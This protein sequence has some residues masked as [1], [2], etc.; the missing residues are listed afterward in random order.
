MTHVEVSL[1]EVAA[2]FEHVD[3]KERRA[4]FR[5]IEGR[6]LPTTE[7]R[8]LVAWID[9]ALDAHESLANQAPDRVLT[10]VPDI[11]FEVSM[12]LWG[13]GGRAE[14]EFIYCLERAAR[15][16][17]DVEV[18]CALASRQGI[19]DADKLGLY[20][21][22]RTS[23]TELLMGAAAELWFA[24]AR[25]ELEVR[26]L[27]AQVIEP[28]SGASADDTLWA[29][30][31]GAQVQ[32]LVVAEEANSDAGGS[33]YAVEKVVRAR[34]SLRSVLE[35]IIDPAASGQVSPAAAQRALKC[36]F[37]GACALLETDHEHVTLLFILI[38]EFYL[39]SLGSRQAKPLSLPSKLP[40]TTERAMVKALQASLPE[41][42]ALMY[43]IGID[44]PARL[45]LSSMTRTHVAWSIERSRPESHLDIAQ[46]L[47]IPADI[48]R[49]ALVRG[50][51]AHELP[52]GYL[53]IG[54][55][56]I[57]DILGV[58]YHRSGLGAV[59]AISQ[60][61]DPQRGIVQVWSPMAN[62]SGATAPWQ[63]G[64]EVGFLR[65]FFRLATGWSY[66]ELKG[67]A[68]TDSALLAQVGKAQIVHIAS[69]GG[70]GLNGQPTLLGGAG[71]SVEFGT[72][73]SL[74]FEGRPLVFLHSCF[75]GAACA[76]GHRWSDLIAAFEAAGAGAIIVCRVE[77]MSEHAPFFAQVFYRALAFCPAQEA[78]TR[79]LSS[80]RSLHDRLERPSNWKDEGDVFLYTHEFYGDP[81]WKMDL[82]PNEREEAEE[83][84]ERWLRRRS[85]GVN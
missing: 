77:V 26:A 64:A 28:E 85:R 61:A 79:A 29:L 33:A 67:D 20:A 8:R 46:T 66:N 75:S 9:R 71:T 36:T 58:S 72:L 50:G 70:R 31:L 62:V 47:S 76:S 81:N 23:W 78:F 42:I 12:A 22:D 1:D 34:E 60:T 55:G 54:K 10:M 41:D 57:D 48:R 40:T 18:L 11:G 35:F 21:S 30:A 25:A 53:S 74:R 73:A 4:R 13:H 45:V 80:L 37:Y 56:P 43:A 65:R 82:R 69:H 39:Y 16:L 6:P 83:D 24:G 7:S 19:D 63:P 68:A 52:G 44:R 51:W 15:M 3:P 5:A 84:L 27:T 2:V 49:V 32:C 59:R 14:S 17:Q 38:V